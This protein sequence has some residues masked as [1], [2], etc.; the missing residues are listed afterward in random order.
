MQIK[1]RHDLILPCL[2]FL[3]E[4]DEDDSFLTNNCDDQVYDAIQSTKCLAFFILCFNL[5][6]LGICLQ[7]MVSTESSWMKVLSLLDLI[8]AVLVIAAMCAWSN[9]NNDMTRH[10]LMIGIRV[11]F[12]HCILNCVLLIACLDDSD[13][14]VN[15]IV[16]RFDPTS[17]FFLLAYFVMLVV[18]N[19]I[20]LIIFDVANLCEDHEIDDVSSTYESTKQLS[21]HY[22]K[23]ELE[24]ISDHPF[25][26]YAQQ[27]KFDDEENMANEMG[28]VN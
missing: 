27:S 16:L 20:I 1:E 2:S 15:G 22:K 11:Y 21:D 12:L 17:V 14:S 8:P 19:F 25:E 5:I 4:I 23:V 7:V 3:P 13:S 18:S 28:I 24:V 6:P 9:D 26:E 10:L